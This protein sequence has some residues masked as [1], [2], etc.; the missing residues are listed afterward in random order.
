MLSTTMKGA[1]AQDLR[2]DGDP[3]PRSLQDDG[4]FEHAGLGAAGRTVNCNHAS[5][6]GAGEAAVPPVIVNVPCGWIWLFASG[7]GVVMS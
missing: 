5:A 6:A 7:N 2:G 4:A 3:R 1:L